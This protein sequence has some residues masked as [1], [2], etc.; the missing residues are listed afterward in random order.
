MDEG[1]RLQAFIFNWPGKKQHAAQLEQML[2][3]HCEVFVINSDDS[4]R[5]KHPHWHHIGNNAYFTEQWNEALKRFDGDVFLHIQADVWPQNVGKM[6]AECLRCMR[7]HNV[8]VYAPDLDFQPQAFSPRSLVPV[9]KGI[10]E[11]PLNDKSI[12]AIKA[13]VLQN[14]PAIDPK[15]NRLGWGTGF[16]VAAVAKRM[17]LRVVRD[18]RFRAGHIRSRGYNTQEASAQWV[19]WMANLDPALRETIEELTRERNRMVLN[20]DSP[21]LLVRGFTGIYRSVRR[22]S[23][24]ARR[25]VLH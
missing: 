12:W 3:Q 15:V 5:N 23:R 20:N 19:A 2:R 21:S 4:L 8:G 7:E 22:F 1:V 16:V 13:A 11:V 18:Y 25:K 9:E 24:I 10:Y 14:T 17:G 6:I